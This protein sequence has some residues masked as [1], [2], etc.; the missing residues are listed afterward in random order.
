MQIVKLLF[1]S[2]CLFTS[3]AYSA[4]VW[5]GVFETKA[6]INK[7]YG[8]TL[9]H[10]TMRLI[11]ND[12]EAEKAQLHMTYDAAY[13][14]GQT[15]STSVDIP[16]LNK[17]TKANDIK[18]EFKLEEQKVV[19]ECCE[20]K[21]DKSVCGVYKIYTT[22]DQ[23]NVALMDTGHFELHLK[24]DN[25]SYSSV[26]KGAFESQKHVSFGGFGYPSI[27]GLIKLAFNDSNPKEANVE[28][29][30]NSWYRWGQMD[31]A[32]AI[33]TSETNAEQM[34]LYLETKS[35]GINFY[36]NKFEDGKPITGYYSVYDRNIICFGKHGKPTVD[37]GCF[38]LLREK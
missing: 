11:L 37:E 8:Y 3:S 12:I 14:R 1:V 18:I 2:F 7:F 19:F 33:I 27:Y 34:N 35:F 29:T 20:F 23:E 38:T 15:V 26:W 4:Q 6:S 17:E 16:L 28:M 13:K 5:E 24:E 22:E 9:V 10:G 25:S 32:P 30:H 21:Y 31:K 36:L